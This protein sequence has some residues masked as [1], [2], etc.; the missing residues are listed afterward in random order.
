VIIGSNNR[1]ETFQQTGSVAKKEEETDLASTKDKVEIN[2]DGKPEGDNFLQKT[3]GKIKD[4]YKKSIV[5]TYQN[6]DEGGK[7]ALHGVAIGT[8]VGGVAGYAAGA[9][10]DVKA[11]EITRTYPVP[12]MEN[13]NLGQIPRDFYQNDWSGWD[14]G[15]DSH[16]HDY[17]PKGWE[18]VNREAPVLD[19]GKN[20]VMA[21]KTET[22]SS[23]TYGKVGGTIMGCAIGAVAGLL[24]GVAFNLIRHFGDAEG[25]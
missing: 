2:K 7:A 5:G 6:M 3:A 23:Q 24:G 18:N 14:H 17:A 9:L 21:S 10:Q 22:I 13:R 12:V 15:P 4:F 1:I 19:T 11:V 8:A 25:K 20:P 16:A